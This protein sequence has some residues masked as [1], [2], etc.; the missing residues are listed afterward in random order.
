MS[1]TYY[2][3]TRASTP[4]EAKIGAFCSLVVVWCSLRIAFG[5]VRIVN[6]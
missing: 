6:P 3:K 4:A 1:A 5:V 2:F